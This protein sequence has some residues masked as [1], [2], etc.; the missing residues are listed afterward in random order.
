M[1]NAEHDR[2]GTKVTIMGDTMELMDEFTA[3]ICGIR[4][5]LTNVFPE[6]ITDYI[7]SFCGKL[8]YTKDEK[9]QHDLL[10][11]LAKV[12]EDGLKELETEN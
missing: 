7:V 5:H 8:A 11:D 4:E 12:L 1:I 10:K 9:E 6:Q 2:G 3:I